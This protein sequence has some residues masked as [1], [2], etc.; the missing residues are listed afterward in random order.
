M[1][2]SASGA[3][4]ISNELKSL[5]AGLS[6]AEAHARLQHYGHNVIIRQ[7]RITAAR[8][9]LSQFRN[10]LILILIA[11]AILSFLLNEVLESAGMVSIVVLSVLLGF[12]QEYRAEKAIESLQKIASPTGR[13]IRN[14]AVQK[15]PAA[16]IVPGDV[17]LLEAGDI[18]PADARLHEEFS[19][20]VNESTLTGESFPSSK[21]ATIAGSKNDAYSRKN[22]VFMGTVVT[23]GKG[24]ATVTETGMRTE[25]GRIAKTLQETEEGQTPLQMKFDTMA[26]QIGIGVGA[27]VAAV[28]LLGLLFE[29]D[30]SVSQMLIFSI[31]LAVA[32]IPSSLPAIVTIS[33]A[34]G[35]KSMTKQNMII[36]KLPATESLGSVTVICSDKTGTLTKNQMTVTRIFIE[37]TAIDVTGAGYEP[38]GEFRLPAGKKKLPDLSLLLRIGFLCSNAKLTQEKGNWGVIGDPTEAALMVLAKKGRLDEYEL[39][40]KF[41]FAQELPF[42]PERKMMSVLYRNNDSGKT[43][44]YVKG[45]PDIV[46]KNCSR[47]IDKGK[48]RK[49]TP[50]DRK[51]ILEQDESF[52]KGSLRVLALAYKQLPGLRLTAKPNTKSVEKELV[53]V[54]LAGMMD[55]PREEVKAA[56]KQCADAGIRVMIITGDHPLTAKAVAEQIGLFMEKDLI[57]TGEQ[58]ERMGDAE[59]EKRIESIRIIARAQP[60]QKSRIVDALKK[61]GHIVAMTG[62]GVNDAP[63]LKKADIGIAMGITGTD[64]AKEAAKST[65]VDDNFASI[66]NAVSEGRNIYDK[67]IKSTRYLLSCNLGEIISVFL[68]IIIKLPLPLVPLQILLMNLLTDGLPAIGLGTESAEKDVMSRS[69]RDPGDKLFNNRMLAIT[70]IFG[71][72]MGIGTLLIFNFYLNQ[73]G[74]GAQQTLMLAQTVAF[75]TLVMFEMFAVHHAA[76]PH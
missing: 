18:I 69:P 23:Y 12:F 45:A 32:A 76:V 2:D 53:F 59:L 3:K 57:L 33:L 27:L 72:I 55:P 11:A 67:I 15:I 65:L 1:D 7:K 31:S 29:N 48:I 71:I 50:L 26:K 38:S 39:S 34:L 8:I 5:K 63:A 25:F 51:R 30:V 40:R 47:I 44:A 4:G 46:L 74:K 17:L 37:N 70:L 73:P 13:V 6:D 56:V 41:S 58:L 42:D 60:I 35:A 20:H 68:A 22:M 14:G 66:V 9:F 49:I 19:L 24:K 64:V 61:K 75:T 28:F 36:K 54:A 16:D 10:F 62:D 21:S 43:E 52:A